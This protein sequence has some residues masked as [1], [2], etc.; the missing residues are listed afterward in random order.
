MYAVTTEGN[1]P[2]G[3]FVKLVET[4]CAELDVEDD[5]S[6]EEADCREE[7]PVNSEDNTDTSE[8]Q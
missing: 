5:T 3:S 8:E 7:S 6:E 4:D 1:A 2:V